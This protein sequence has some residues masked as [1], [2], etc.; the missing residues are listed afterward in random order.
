[1]DKRISEEK[2]EVIA[3]YHEMYARRI[4]MLYEEYIF[5]LSQ[6]LRLEDETVRKV[7]DEQF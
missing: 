2:R 5:E 3:R 1:M 4:E 7:W 6:K